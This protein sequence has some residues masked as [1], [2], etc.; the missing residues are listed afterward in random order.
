[1]TV[2]NMSNQYGPVSIKVST[3]QSILWNQMTENRKKNDRDCCIRGFKERVPSLIKYANWIRV[4]TNK[5]SPISFQLVIARG[6][7]F[8]KCQEKMPNMSIKRQKN[9]YTRGF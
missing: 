4:T 7:A 8:E 5:Q 3:E 2:K 6:L 1:M 9:K